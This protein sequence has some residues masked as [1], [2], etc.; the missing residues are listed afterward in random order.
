MK[1]LAGVLVLT[2]TGSIFLPPALAIQPCVPLVFALDGSLTLKGEPASLGIVL[3]T[4]LH[5]LAAK[6]RHST[7]CLSV[8]KNT[9]YSD[10]AMAIA[11]IQRAGLQINMIGLFTPPR[12]PTSP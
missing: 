6:K 9:R 7:I 4:K 10:V 1:L 12:N 11:A 8:D 2:A 5:K 3:D